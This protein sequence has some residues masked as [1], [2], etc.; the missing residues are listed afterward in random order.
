MK[1]VSSDSIRMASETC[2][3]AVLGPGE[4]V[5][6]ADQSAAASCGKAR[7]LDVKVVSQRCCTQQCRLHFDSHVFRACMKC[8]YVGQLTQHQSQAS[9]HSSQP[10]SQPALLTTYRASTQCLL[11][12]R[13]YLLLTTKPPAAS[14][15]FL[16][17]G[18]R[19]LDNLQPDRLSY[20]QHLTAS[21]PQSKVATP[22][23]SRLPPNVQP[24]L[25]QVCGLK[26]Q[27]RRLIMDGRC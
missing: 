25:L 12:C 14:S 8:L 9:M 19:F 2:T 21:A 22:H 5:A 24:S 16:L 7:M 6:T 1:F 27:Q 11:P 15:L 20:V 13:T 18:I 17:L 23:E 4:A 10:A 3:P 26:A